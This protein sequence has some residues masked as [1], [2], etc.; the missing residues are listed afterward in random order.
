MEDNDAS[1]DGT[2]PPDLSSHSS[3]SMPPFKPFRLEV[4]RF[5]GTE[6]QLT[7]FSLEPKVI[8]Q[9]GHIDHST[10]YVAVVVS[11][12]STVDLPLVPLGHNKNN[13]PPLLPAFTK[14]PTCSDLSLMS[15]PSIMLAHDKGTNNFFTVAVAAVTF[16]V[17]RSDRSEARKEEQRIQELAAMKQRDED[18]AREIELLKQKVAE[19]EELSKGRGL[20]GLFH[21]RHPHHTDNE[22]AKST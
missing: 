16:E 17:Q 13:P 6:L 1:G 15:L 5:D 18:L 12:K 11:H 2:P 20:S 22:K 4:P 14:P 9:V 8:S 7:T 10:Y 19:L 3:G 21:I